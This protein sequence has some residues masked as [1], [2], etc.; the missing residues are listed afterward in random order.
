MDMRYKFLLPVI[1][2]G[3]GSNAVKLFM[4]GSMIDSIRDCQITF[5]SSVTPVPTFG[6]SISQNPL[7]EKHWNS[8]AIQDDSFLAQEQMDL[9][10]AR[11]YSEISQL[12]LAA[13]N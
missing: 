3:F 12:V 9:V 6:I 8:F 13:W 5:S 7:S 1:L 11:Y 2:S 4:M 10:K